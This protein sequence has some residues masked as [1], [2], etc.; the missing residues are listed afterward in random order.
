MS[1][2][3]HAIKT[4]KEDIYIPRLLEA[5]AARLAN[6]GTLN[7]PTDVIY[8]SDGFKVRMINSLTFSMCV[9]LKNRKF[10]FALE[11]FPLLFKHGF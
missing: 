3:D 6:P 10:K 4:H 11:T 8:V 5:L 2:H 7:R 9:M 1:A